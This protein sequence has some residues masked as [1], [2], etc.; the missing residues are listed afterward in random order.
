M[1][2]AR[3]L[4]MEDVQRQDHEGF[5]S[6]ISLGT[7]RMLLYCVLSWGD[8]VAFTTSCG[9]MC[10]RCYGKS[11]L[12]THPLFAV[13]TCGSTAQVVS[14]SAGEGLMTYGSLLNLVFWR[15]ASF[16]KGLVGSTGTLVFFGIVA[17]LLL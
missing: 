16:G 9:N 13:A 2:H 1:A 4:T 10:S 8:H 15:Y 12:N 3:E 7:S 6:A 5:S 17:F 14:K 11:N